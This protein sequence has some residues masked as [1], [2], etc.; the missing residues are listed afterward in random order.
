[1]RLS[2]D[3]TVIVLL[4]GLTALYLRAV[5]ILRTRGY[6]V[7]AFQQAC[8]HT[9][10][11]LQAIALLGPLDPAADELLSAHMA[12]HLLIADVAAPFLLAGIRTPVLVF[13]LPRPVL[14]ALARRR[15][16]RAAFRWL[17]QPLVAIPVFL[18]VLYTWHFAFAF[19]GA[20]RHPLVHVLQHECFVAT[21]LLVWWSAL[22]PKRRR[23]RGEL[24]KIPYI[25][26]ARMG[27]M[28]LGMAFLFMRTPAYG[29][30][31]GD[32]PLKHGITPLHDQQLA[33][34]MMMVLDI[35][36]MVFALCFFFWRASED[37][38]AA[39]RREGARAAQ[40]SPVA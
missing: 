10:V 14:V 26:A 7:P 18:A 38:V 32:L 19:E 15:R 8:W 27:S 33:G 25:F 23:L 28:F 1:M 22:E 30:Y 2:L 17:R 21:G 35:L 37:D 36:I 11:A 3:P 13:L 6:R 5:H 31:Y 39:E 40:A 24:W 20:L 4:A 29:A 9:G 16:L 34:G 12:Q